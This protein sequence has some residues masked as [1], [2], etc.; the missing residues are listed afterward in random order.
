MECIFQIKSLLKSRIIKTAITNL[1]FLFYILLSMAF[2]RQVHIINHCHAWPLAD[3][4]CL[5][6]AKS[7]LLL[8]TIC[9]FIPLY[10]YLYWFYCWV[11]IAM[12]NYTEKNISVYLMGLCSCKHFHNHCLFRSIYIYVQTHGYPETNIIECN[13][14]HQ[15][16]YYARRN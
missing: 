7:F 8:L 3:L 16:Y 4:S 10:L 5:H 11:I 1:S 2:S 9:C 14:C 13:N 15:C 12:W 6:I